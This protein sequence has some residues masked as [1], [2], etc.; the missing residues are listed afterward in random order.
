M[1]HQPYISSNFLLYCF[2]ENPIKLN[3]GGEYELVP[4]KIWKKNSN[5]IESEINTPQNGIYGDVILE[6]NPHIIN[7]DNNLYLGYTAGFNNG[8]NT[9]I[10]YYYINIPID[11]NLNIIGDMSIITKSFSSCF[12]QDKLLS[13]DHKHGNDKLIINEELFKLPFEY[14]FI[15][16]VTNIF[17]DQNKFIVTVA[18]ENNIYH[19]YLLDFNNNFKEIKN[20]ANE[21]IYKCSILNNKLAYA[22][23]NS[24]KEEARIIIEETFPIDLNKF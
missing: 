22:V 3:F 9:P 21:S 16:R 14:Q 20:L 13:I 15:Y 18:D 19:S 8:L 5:G 17:N 7:K 2:A 12:I 10:V 6:C 11:D 23:K 24:S 1:K 4:W